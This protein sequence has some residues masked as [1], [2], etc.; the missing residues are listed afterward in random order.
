[1]KYI[2]TL[3]LALV[4]VLPLPAQNNDS[5]QDERTEGRRD[6]QKKFDP[7][8]YQRELEACIIREACLTKQEAQRLPQ[9]NPAER[10]RV[11]FVSNPELE[12][13]AKENPLAVQDSPLFKAVKPNFPR[14]P[15]EGIGLRGAAR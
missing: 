10:D 13:L 2:I 12:R 15:V 3:I 8:R 9:S 11:T 5:R 7:E 14:I 4:M 6:E 1:M